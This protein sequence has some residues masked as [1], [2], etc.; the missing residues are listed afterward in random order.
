MNGDFSAPPLN[1]YRLEWTASGNGRMYSGNIYIKCEG[2]PKEDEAIR[3]VKE[4]CGIWNTELYGFSIRDI[5]KFIFTPYY[6][7]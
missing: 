1:L 3:V 6:I 7:M 5:E 4:N 2:E